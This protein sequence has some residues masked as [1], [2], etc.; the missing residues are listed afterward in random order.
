M[1]ISASIFIHFP[2][3]TFCWLPPE[4]WAVTSFKEGVL[5]FSAST[6]EW[7]DS[8]IFA[9]FRK[10]PLLNPFIFARI[11]LVRTSRESTSPC[12]F[13][14]SVKKAIFLRIASLGVLMVTFSPL[15]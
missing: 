10:G 8:S 3:T 13:R 9:L 15:T 4:S 12:P 6:F 14:S 7:P 1:K 5:I 11:R 2:M